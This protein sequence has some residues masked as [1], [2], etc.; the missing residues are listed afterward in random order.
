MSEE[1]K[2]KKRR[3]IVKEYFTNAEEGSILSAI[4]WLINFVKEL[5]SG[6]NAAL[7]ESA[8]KRLAKKNGEL[9]DDE[10]DEE[11]NIDRE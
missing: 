8:A 1:K 5:I 6:L 2:K 3:N 10:I 7:E 11:N 9:I 4:V